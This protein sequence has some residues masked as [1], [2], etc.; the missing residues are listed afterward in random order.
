[1]E[2]IN[3]GLI[4]IGIIL[5][6]DNILRFRKFLDTQ[7]DIIS[8]GTKYLERMEWLAY[9]LLILFFIGYGFVL[10]TNLQSTVIALILCGGSIFVTIVENVMI[11]Q[12]NTIKNRTYDISEMM[13]DV[14]EARDPNLTGHSL[15]VRNLTMLL[16]SHLPEEMRRQVNEVSLSYAALLHDI[17]KLGVPESILNKPDKLT[18]EEWNIMRQHPKIGV[19]I[20]SK[21]HTFDSIAPWIQDHHERI[22]GNGYYG[23]PGKDIPLAARIISVC[24]TYS[25]ITT[26]RPYKEARS[27]EQAEKIMKS[28]AGTQLDK[29]LVDIFFSI[30]KAEVEG[31]VPQTTPDLISLAAAKEEN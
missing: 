26:K 28:V 21:I 14:V 18:P 15:H 10:S 6:A 17:G 12:V 1:M 20:L 24:D 19:R 8:E 13:V 25:V 16:Y 11:E 7:K 30:P 23:V 4:I 3:A 22:D 2:T 5:M 31:C 29:Q 27:Y 9:I